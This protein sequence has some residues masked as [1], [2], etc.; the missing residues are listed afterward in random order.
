MEEKEQMNNTSTNIEELRKAEEL[1]KSCL[2]ITEEDL[3]YIEHPSLKYAIYSLNI[4]EA[5]QA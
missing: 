1:Y 5:F 3:K 2:I 4:Y